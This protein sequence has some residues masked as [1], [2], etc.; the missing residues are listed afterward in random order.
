MIKQR[1]DNDVQCVSIKLF[2]NDVNNAFVELI[3]I[4][5]LPIG[6]FYYSFLFFEKK[7][8]DKKHTQKQFIKKEEK[9]FSHIKSKD[10]IAC[11][12]FLE[13]IQK[14]KVRHVML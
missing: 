5:W 2:E 11:V 9:T 7:G 6:W 12:F 8:I 13:N 3:K 4:F 14:K 10:V 1:L